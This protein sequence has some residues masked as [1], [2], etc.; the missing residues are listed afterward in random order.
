MKKSIIAVF[1]LSSAALL[2]SCATNSGA[3]YVGSDPDYTGY[4]LGLGSYNISNGYGPEF[5][6]PANPGFNNYNYNY[7][8]YNR[9]PVGRYYN[10]YYGHGGRYYGGRVGRGGFRR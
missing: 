2:S 1:V 10:R 8:S 9:A 7:V 4:T 6:N 5:W 3:T